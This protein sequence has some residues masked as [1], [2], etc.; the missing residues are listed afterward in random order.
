L[1]HISSVI[2]V[3]LHIFAA[4][5]TSILAL[6]PVSA[7]EEII[8]LEALSDQGTFQIDILWMPNHIGSSNI[9]EIRFIDP[10]ICREIEDVKYDIS[11]HRDGR[12]EVERSEQVSIFQDFVF[13][14][15]GSYEI[16][17]DNI[18]DLGEWVSIPIHV[19]P[20]FHEIFFLV[21]AVALC[22]L[23]FATTITTRSKRSNLFRHL[24]D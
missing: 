21:Y 5:L 20:E 15:M 12:P 6:Q 11:I 3:I 1:C 23:V 24:I 13:E 22:I 16:R 17:L 8:M 18:E 9:F 14:A 19:T 4:L 7:Q 2:I 10:D